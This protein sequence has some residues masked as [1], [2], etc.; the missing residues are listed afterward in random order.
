MNRLC[1]RDL[2]FLVKDA[3]CEKITQ[4]VEC[5]HEPRATFKNDMRTGLPGNSILIL[6]FLHLQHNLQNFGEIAPNAQSSVIRYG[7]IRKLL[8]H[9]LVVQKAVGTLY[10]KGKQ[11]GFIDLDVAGGSDVNLR[12][13]YRSTITYGI[14]SAGRTVV[15]MIAR[16]E[17]KLD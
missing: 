6:M 1:D 11:R 3:V 14:N 13:P 17:M 2:P 7:K 8:H 16:M 15:S 10:C 5:G 12:K 4:P 9:F